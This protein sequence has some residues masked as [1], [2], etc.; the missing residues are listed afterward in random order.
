[1]AVQ[2]VVIS[3]D[4]Y[5]AAEEE[6]RRKDELLLQQ[7]V[8]AEREHLYRAKEWKRIAEEQSL[9]YVDLDTSS[10]EE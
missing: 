8:A 3:S 10:D 6:C 7:G 4:T 5:T 9:L 1:V 2:V